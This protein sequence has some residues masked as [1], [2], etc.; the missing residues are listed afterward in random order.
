M[1]AIGAVRVK[2]NSKCS[3]HK[4]DDVIFVCKETGCHNQLAC[5]KCVTTVHKKHDLENLSNMISGKKD[6]IRQGMDSV[7]KRELP[8]LAIVIQATEQKTQRIQKHLK[9]SLTT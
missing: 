4:K 1:A 5:V 6:K 8:T 7:E 3:H 9:H 2:G